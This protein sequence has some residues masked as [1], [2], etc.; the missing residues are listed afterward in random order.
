MAFD[1]VFKKKRQDI[2]R[3][4]ARHGTR[5]VRVFG[6]VAR[7]QAESDSDIDFLVR[8]EPGFTLLGHAALVR[9]LEALL[10]RKVDVV[11][12][13]GLRPR[14]RDRVLQEALPL[15]EIHP[16]RRRSCCPAFADATP[17]ASEHTVDG[18]HLYAECPRPPLLRNRF[19]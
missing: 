13:R 6:S 17:A 5:H 7:G 3:I 14:I 18:Y 10:G 4:A 8:L 9:E 19:Q 1:E 12:D 16:N 2:L 11:S 15:R